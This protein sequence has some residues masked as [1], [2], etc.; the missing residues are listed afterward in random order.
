MKGEVEV[1]EG[2]VV[3]EPGELEGVA[4]PTS[5]ADAG[6][7][8]EDDVEELEVAHGGGLGPGDEAVDALGQVG[9]MQAGG[10]VADAGGEELAHA[11]LPTLS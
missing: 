1:V 4:E 3:R 7:F 5:F 11:T 2:L 6:L 9:E 10:G 8:L